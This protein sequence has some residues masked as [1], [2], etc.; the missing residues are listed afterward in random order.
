[1]GLALP[2]PGARSHTTPRGYDVT[3]LLAWL[4]NPFRG[5]AERK[6]LPA[7]Q[8]LRAQPRPMTGFMAT[9]SAEQKSAALAYCGDDTH[10]DSTP[11]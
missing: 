6:R 4:S 5:G 8:P 7:L 10:G 3:A 11:H 9:L 1:M 2:H